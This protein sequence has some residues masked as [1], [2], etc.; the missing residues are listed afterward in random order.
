MLCGDGPGLRIPY[1]GL[2]IRRSIDRKSVVRIIARPGNDQH[3][4][5]IQKSSMN[6][7]HR[8]LVR[9]RAPLPA[10]FG[11]LERA[12]RGGVWGPGGGGGVGGVGGWG[13]SH[14]G[15]VWV[16]DF[17]PPPPPQP[18]RVLAINKDTISDTILIFILSD[19]LS[20]ICRA[21]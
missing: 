15:G 5:R 13:F 7:V 18:I 6:R 4:S 19:V 2:I 3:F 20:P 14:E 8:H 11:V 17:S 16:R 9:K 21:T 10:R 1:R 12:G